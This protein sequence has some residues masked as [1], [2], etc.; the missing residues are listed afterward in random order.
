MTLSRS[1]RLIKAMCSELQSS[2][3]SSR[4]MAQWNASIGSASPF[5]SKAISCPCPCGRRARSQGSRRTTA[6]SCN[7]RSSVPAVTRCTWEGPAGSAAATDRE[8]R[9]DRL[10]HPSA[11]PRP[12][13]ATEHRGGS[14][15]RW[16]C[17]RDQDDRSSVPAFLLPRKK[18]LS[19][20]RH[21]LAQPMMMFWS[22]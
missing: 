3:A 9:P 7:R 20:R 14:E 12:E 13:D 10:F 2:R 5:V 11:I 1:A 8:A 4:Y 18:C 21:H 15:V 6:P 19:N 22:K 17:P 16:A